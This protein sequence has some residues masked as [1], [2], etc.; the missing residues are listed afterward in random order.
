MAVERVL[1][2]NNSI[3]DKK[4]DLRALIEADY[5][6]VPATTIRHAIGFMRVAKPD[7]LISAFQLPDGDADQVLQTIKTNTEFESIPV[8]VLLDGLEG[9][10]EAQML[11]LGAAAVF[12]HRQGA[13]QL[14]KEVRKIINLRG[15]NKE[16]DVMG[17]TGQLARLGIVELIREMAAEHGSGIISID[18]TTQM[19]IYLVDGQIVHSR[20][21]ITVAKKALFRCLRIAEAAFH[22]SNEQPDIE[23]TIKDDLDALI[24][25]ARESNQR[26]MANS[27]RLPQPHHRIRINFT[28][29]LKKTALKPEARAAFEVIKR[30][31]RVKDYVDRFNVA[32]TICYEYLFT[33]SERGFIDITDEQ[34]GVA[35]IVDSSCDMTEE[36]R[37][38]GVQPILLRLDMSDGKSLPDVPSSL[39]S[40][41]KYKTKQLESAVI[42]TATD[43]AFL[44]R[45]LT[46]VVDYDCISLFPAE[47]LVPIKHRAIRNLVKLRQVGHQGQPLMAHEMMY[48]ETK[49]FSLGLGLLA[50]QA[51]V[52]AQDQA[53]TETIHEFISELAPRVYM[54][55][56]VQGGKSPMSPKGNSTM[57]SVWD[58][59]HFKATEEIA[60]GQSVVEPLAALLLKRVNTNRPVRMAV[61]HINAKSVAQELQSYLA[62]RITLNHRFEIVELG[63]VT[64]SILGDGAVA[65]AFHQ[66]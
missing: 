50:Y 16:N 10:R 9:D 60:K 19:D 7:V 58:Q 14:L 55:V 45:N 47:E 61:G 44:E 62:D 21:G 48:V 39:N 37:N 52:M 15:N 40:L 33:F 46:S 1:Y 17:I 56:A 24:E 66:L 26:L 3:E 43:D 59:D 12:D 13:S 6:I 64:A 65:L 11:K 8:I 2:L 32:D 27:H 35:V 18:G 28:D 49:T 41:L 20:H 57:I 31:P 23:P 29:E 36:L 38:D 5:E 22:F 42:S 30:F 34:R 54:S 53:A 25:E 51:A 63:P 4:R